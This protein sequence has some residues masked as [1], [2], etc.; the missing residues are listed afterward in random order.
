MQVLQTVIEVDGEGLKALMGEQVLL[1][2]ANY[3]YAG[4]LVGVN[5]TCVK[6]E[7]PSIVYDTGSFSSDSWSDAQRLHADEWYV[8]LSAI[9]SFGK[10]K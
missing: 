1:M 7:E 5:D 4:K 3:F 6:L 10:G 9:E 8:Q 2:C